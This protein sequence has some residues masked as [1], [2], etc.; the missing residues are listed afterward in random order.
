MSRVDPTR[1][2]FN[3]VMRVLGDLVDN[4]VYNDPNSPEHYGTLHSAMMQ[5]V[6]LLGVGGAAL[7]E[8]ERAESA[9]KLLDCVPE[10]KVANEKPLPAEVVLR[11]VVDHGLIYW[12]PTTSRGYIAKALMLARAERALAESGDGEARTTAYHAA[13]ANCA[14][15]YLWMQHNA[16]AP[17]DDPLLLFTQE[18]N[19]SCFSGLPERKLCRWLGYIQGVL[20]ER[21]LTTV[22]AERDWTR[23]YFRP[24]D[25][26]SE[27]K[28]HG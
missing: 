22:E 8:I 3:A 26:P 10:G 15:R 25:F 13:L 21:G 16:G 14:N 28:A 27:E 18:L 9:R 4:G 23:P 19:K 1:E 2:D 12:E 5:I 17:V 11:D 6:G 7:Q 24:L 20:I